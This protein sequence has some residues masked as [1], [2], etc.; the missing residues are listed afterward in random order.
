MYLLIFWVL[1]AHSHGPPDSFHPIFHFTA[2]IT[3]SSSLHL[4]NILPHPL[5]LLFSYL[6]FSPNLSLLSFTHFL[7]NLLSFSYLLHSSVRPLDRHVVCEVNEQLP[8]NPTDYC[9]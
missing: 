8:S 6:T 1:H 9:Q 2:Q 4:L 3:L 7:Q 5:S